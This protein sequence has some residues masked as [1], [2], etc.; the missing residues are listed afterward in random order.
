MPKLKQ[1][2]LFGGLILKKHSN[3]RVCI[4]LVL[5]VLAS[6][7]TLPDIPRDLSPF[8]L[9]DENASLYMSVPVVGNEDIVRKLTRTL[10]LGIDSDSI[11]T[12][13]ERTNTLHIAV[14][15]EEGIISRESTY[16][17]LV[18]TGSLPSV[19]VN[20]AL[21]EKNGWTKV[22]EEI[23]EVK[24][25]RKKTHLGFELAILKS[26]LIV[27]SNKN[28]VSVQQRY[29]QGKMLML[30][31]PSILDDSNNETEISELLH[32]PNALT[33]YIPMAGALLPQILGVPIELAIDYAVG[34]I[35]S[36]DKSNFRVNFQLQMTDANATKV[37]MT[38]LA[39]ASLGMNFAIEEKPNNIIMLDNLIINSA[40]LARFI[41]QS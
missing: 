4:F 31:W 36:Y 16:F 32:N 13:I 8:A 1:E 5:L 39:I 41:N 25:E 6:C 40:F 18:L 7:K 26:N 9:F 34:T 14:F 33:L 11:E 30:D 2:N 21:T 12:L 10:I 37:A 19:F 27:V 17:Q 29:E 28:V 38:L 20:A 23:D 24:Y 22:T 3:Y 35:M 15:T